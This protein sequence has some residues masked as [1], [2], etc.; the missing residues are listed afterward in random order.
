MSQDI[1]SF[2]KKWQLDPYGHMDFM[3]PTG[4]QGKLQ[5]EYI[6]EAM[7]DVEM[8]MSGASFLTTTLLASFAALVTILF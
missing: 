8:D 3:A 1:P 6:Q 5:L 4:E 7:K 2:A